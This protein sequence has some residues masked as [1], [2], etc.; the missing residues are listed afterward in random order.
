MSNAFDPDEYPIIGEPLP[1]EFANTLYSAGGQTIDFLTSPEAIRQWFTL[2]ASHVDLPTDVRQSDADSVRDLRN[3]IHALLV[4]LAGGRTPDAG[5]TAILNR[6]AAKGPWFLQLNVG[7]ATVTRRH[8]V[9]AIDALLGRIANDTIDL[10]AGPSRVLLRQCSGPGCEMLFVKNHHK[11]RWC[12]QSCGH[13]ARQ[14]EYYRRKRA[15][16]GAR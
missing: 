11:R 1:V 6:Y 10:V 13:R 12:H 7:S 9:K 14:A 3:T 16:V 5:S 8:A 15:V 2:A 4:T